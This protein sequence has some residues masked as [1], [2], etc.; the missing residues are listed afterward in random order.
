MAAWAVGSAP[1]KP[2]GLSLATRALIWLP[3]SAKGPFVGSNSVDSYSGV[4]GRAGPW[5]GLGCNG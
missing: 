2:S 5:A 4:L 1:G 3:R